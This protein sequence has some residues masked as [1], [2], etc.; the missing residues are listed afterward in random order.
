MS[1]FPGFAPLGN[2][3]DVGMSD[4]DDDSSSSVSRTADHFGSSL[5]ISPPPLSIPNPIANYFAVTAA[6]FPSSSMED[7]TMGLGNT[8]TI[9]ATSLPLTPAVRPPPADANPAPAKDVFAAPPPPASTAAQ[10]EVQKAKPQAR[11][12]VPLEK[13]YSQMVWLRLMQTEP[14][15][16]GRLFSQFSICVHCSI[17]IRRMLQFFGTQDCHFSSLIVLFLFFRTQGTVKEEVDQYG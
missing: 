14:D 4:A 5:R 10:V 3:S 6:Y 12:K 8:S 16:A 15:L 11:N 7:T 9:S 2:N 1:Q 17:H 13:G